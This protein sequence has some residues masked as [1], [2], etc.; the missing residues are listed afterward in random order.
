MK[1]LVQYADGDTKWRWYD[2]DLFKT[3]QYG[4]Y[5]ARFPYLMHLGLD[6][7]EAA[8]FKKDF[9]NK[10]IE[11]VKP[12]DV[13]YVDVAFYGNGWLNETTIPDIH[14]KVYV[15]EFRYTHWYHDLSMGKNTKADVAKTKISATCEVMGKSY[16]LTAYLVFAYGSNKILDTSRMELLTQRHAK[17][18]PQILADSL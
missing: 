6:L 3:I 14:P 15:L 4:E 10:P 17:L 7:A 16:A 11:Q 8:A 1:Y 2:Q 5:V 9:K 12:G 13:V 18:Y